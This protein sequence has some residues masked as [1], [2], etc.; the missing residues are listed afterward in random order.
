MKSE[1]SEGG[2][3]F[4]TAKMSG[5]LNSVWFIPDKTKR[6]IFFFGVR[7]SMYSY[8]NPITYKIQ[9]NN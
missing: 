8:S 3:S 6:P 2:I 9:T 7:E 1:D 4:P 5:L